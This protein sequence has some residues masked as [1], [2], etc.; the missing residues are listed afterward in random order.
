MYPYPAYRTRIAPRSP[1]AGA[2]RQSTYAQRPLPAA[3]RQRPGVPM[4][5]AAPQKDPRVAGTPTPWLPSPMGPPYPEPEV[6]KPMRPA[7][8]PPVPPQVT[9]R[10]GMLTVHALNSTMSSLLSMIREKTGIEFDGA[11][12]SSE[13]VAVSMGPA[14]EGDVLAAIFAGSSFD[15][16][17]LGRADS[18]DIVQR[19]ILTPKGKAPPSG[20]FAGNQPFR[21]PQTQPQQADEDQ[22]AADDA[23]PDNGDPDPQDTANQP[24]ANPTQ[25][26]IAQNQ[27]QNNGPKTPEQLLQELKQMQLRQQQQQGQPPPNPNIVPRKVPPQE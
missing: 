13:R 27:D 18:P 4:R 19:V 21:Q 23:S 24:P 9:F 2:I 17:V 10:N 22:D 15:Y 3:A 6:P 1:S 20:T 25:P 8:M 5:G 14:A 26:P 7:D 12:N 11:E 16:V